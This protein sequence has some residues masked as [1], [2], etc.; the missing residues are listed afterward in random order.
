MRKKIKTP[1][2]ELI[3]ELESELYHEKEKAG[4]RYAIAI[5][6][7]MLRKEKSIMC[8]FAK[9]WHHAKKNYQ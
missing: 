1:L 6:R 8:W 2:T 7:R 5:A 4:L 9:E 3:E